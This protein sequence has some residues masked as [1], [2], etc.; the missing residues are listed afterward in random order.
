M[1]K[2]PQN[3]DIVLFTEAELRCK[4]TKKVS[5]LA[6]FA[7]HLAYLRVR[8]AQPMTVTSCCRSKFHNKAISGHPR[9]LHIYDSERHGVTGCLAID[10]RIPNLVY[11]A[12]LVKIALNE[13]WSV[14]VSKTFIHLDRRDMVGL[15]QGLFG[16]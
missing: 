9:S 7:D 6:G 2:H 14:G 12:D 10:I 3:D 13:G 1:I 4:S 11:A 8:L 16:Y 5:L 15:P